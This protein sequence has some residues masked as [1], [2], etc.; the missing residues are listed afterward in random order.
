M[1]VPCTEDQ[2]TS[3]VMLDASLPRHADEITS[4]LTQ[5][6]TARNYTA[7][8]TPTLGVPF[9]YLTSRC[10]AHAGVIV[11]ADGAEETALSVIAQRDSHGVT[12]LPP[13]TLHTEP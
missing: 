10:H 13:S 2:S 6:Q 4:K 5:K 7:S 12:R 11:G 1:H 3:T 9:H 8:F